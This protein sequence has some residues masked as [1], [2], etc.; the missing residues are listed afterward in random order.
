MKRGFLSRRNALLSPKG[1]SAGVAA[2]LIVFV[3]AL[4][5]MIAPNFFLTLFT[6]AF[7]VGDAATASVHGVLAGFEDTAAL[8]KE[9]ERLTAQNTALMLENRTLQDKQ[10]TFTAL[11]AGPSSDTGVLAG[12]L[13]RPPETAYDTLILGAGLENGVALGME[14]FAN[15]GTPVGV[16]GKVDATHALVSLFSSYG[17]ISHGWVG[18]EHIPL[19]LKGAGGGS[20]SAVLPRSA[21]VV[22]GDLVY[23]PG[24]GALPVGTV[25]RIDA[26]PASPEQTLRIV[27]VTNLFSLTWVL[28]RDG[29]TAFKDMLAASSTPL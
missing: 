3:I 25:G 22:V 6:P 19:T 10:Q 29:G 28:V 20:F 12:V 13:A 7:T 26:D 27:P 18:Q 1:I 17:R 15:G 9:N 14:V 23:L 11:L 4:V 21:T 16:I 8:A 24:P 2:V 5:R